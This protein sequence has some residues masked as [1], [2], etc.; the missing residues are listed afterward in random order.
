MKVVLLLGAGATLSDVAT[1]PH[2]YRPPLDKHFFAEA[3]LTSPVLVRNVRRYLLETYDIDIR[4]PENDSLEGVMGQIYPDLFNPR[5]AER[6][7]I[8]FRTLLRL[9]NTRLAATTNELRPTN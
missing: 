2:K 9:F 4:Y 8:A 7:L 1:K 6:A 5:L 3:A